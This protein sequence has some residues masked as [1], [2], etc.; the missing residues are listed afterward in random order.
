[1]SLLSRTLALAAAWFIAVPPTFAAQLAPGES[2][3]VRENFDVIFT[4]GINASSDPT[5]A[6]TVVADVTREFSLPVTTE[7]RPSGMPPQIY[8]ADGTRCTTGWCAARTPARSTS[9]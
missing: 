1:M 2:V 6:G 9:T 8:H 7:F 5:L 3:L 4:P